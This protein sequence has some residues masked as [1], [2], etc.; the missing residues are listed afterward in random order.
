MTGGLVLTGHQNII[1]GTQ[2]VIGKVFLSLVQNI[3]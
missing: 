2:K 1:P 3:R